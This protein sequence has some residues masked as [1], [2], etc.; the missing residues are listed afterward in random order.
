MGLAAFV[1]LCDLPTRWINRSE[2]VWEWHECNKLCSRVAMKIGTRAS[3]MAMAQTNDIVQ[4]LKEADPALSPVAETMSSMGDRDQVSKLLVHGG[5]GGAFV[6]EIRA[7]LRAGALQAAMHSLKDMPG[8]EETPD[9]I[10][11]AYLKREAMGDALVL[12]HGL[13]LD[14]FQRDGGH[15]FKIGTNAVRRAAY[16]RTLYPQA[17]IIHFRG[18]VNTR[19]DKIDQAIPQKLPDGGVVGPADALIVAQAGLDRLGLSNRIAK[20]LSP[21]DMLP[22]IGQGIVVVECQE[23]NWPV[24]ET[25]EKIDC[26]KARQCALAEREVLWMLNGH[27]NSPIAG[28][29]EIDSDVMHLK[30]SVLNLEGD[31]M[32]EAESSGDRNRPRE[33]GRAVALSLIEQGCKEI[34][35]MAR[36][37]MS[38]P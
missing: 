2:F 21:A 9:L 16:C 37:H 11:G 34:I 28:Y 12:R 22:A 5:K 25:L 30:A 23:N 29:A 32:I 38:H 35:E 7:A 24:R 17:E 1:F 20:R 33:I 19:I 14:E 15:G 31:R 6:A 4:R 26:P 10:I 3:A 13:S 36:H 8:D 27:C 18:A